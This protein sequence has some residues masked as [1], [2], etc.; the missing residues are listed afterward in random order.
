MEEPWPG[1]W[2]GTQTQPIMQEMYLYQATLKAAVKVSLLQEE[3]LDNNR[4]QGL[5][6]V[7]WQVLQQ[8]EATLV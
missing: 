2:R 1:Y 8:E 6:A 4:Q 7:E 3:T 5:D